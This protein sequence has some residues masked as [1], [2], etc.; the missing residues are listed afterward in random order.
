MKVV[1]EPREDSLLILSE[2]KNYA[3]GSVLDIGTGSGI[4][5][6]E[7]RRY[8]KRVTATDIDSKSLLVS[9]QNAKKEGCT[10]IKFIKSDLFS[11]IKGRFDCIIFN[12]PYL[13]GW[14]DRRTDGGKHGL[15]VIG[16]FLKDLGRFLK[17]DGNALIIFSSLTRRNR[18][19]GLIEKYFLE[20]DKIKDQ[21][22][23]FE[24]LYLYRIFKSKLMAKLEKLG[25]KDL[26]LIARGHRGIVYKAEFN[27][28]KVAVKVERKDSAAIDRIKNEAGW[29][30]ILNKRNIGPKLI[31]DG[32]GFIIMEFVDGKLITDFLKS[33][34]KS[35]IISIISNIFEQLYQMDKLG[36]DKEELHNPVKHIIVD[37]NPVLIDFER[38][39]RTEKPKNIT[40][41]CQF[42]S[43]KK[44]HGI[45]GAKSV[46]YEPK[47]LW[48]LA[49]EYKAKRSRKR[50]DKI[51]NLFKQKT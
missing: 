2:I 17:E 19:E 35:E 41:F 44:I 49:G 14:T 51:V 46:N 15:E 16:R 47:V 6:I 42:L 21:K 12:P 45:L 31:D 20:F 48:E 27:R 26:E 5:A 10:N 25:V 33:S 34:V 22:I 50:L 39:H 32:E 29:L 13:P 7:A 1:Y 3:H 38:C 37:K 30:K 43:S 18:V 9:Q 23:F 36:V 24:T 40:Q 11:K 8:S 28:K 4:L